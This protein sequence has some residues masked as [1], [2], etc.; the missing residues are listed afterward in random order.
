MGLDP[1]PGADN[2]GDWHERW[3]ARLQAAQSR[4]DTITIWVDPR[5]PSQSLIDPSPRWQLLAFRVPFALVFT[6]VG[7]WAAWVCVHVLRELLR[8]TRD[9][10]GP[11][12][13]DQGGEESA[14]G[15]DYV[16]PADG[17]QS[18]AGRSAGAIWLFSLFWCGIAFPMAGVL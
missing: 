13:G 15:S 2:L 11:G 9:G 3:H 18:P 1:N 4:R 16:L 10:W 7:L 14:E 6:G 12:V 8:R 17:G 5:Q